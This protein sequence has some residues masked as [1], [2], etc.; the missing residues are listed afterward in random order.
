MG[1]TRSKPFDISKVLVFEAWK[2]VKANGGSYGVDK[3]SVK[4]FESN[5]KDNLYKLWNRLSSG[6]YFPPPVRRVEIPKSGGGK[7]PLGIP[8]VADRVA[9]MVVKMAL[10]PKVEPHFHKDSYGYRPGRSAI[11]AVGVARKRCWRYAWVVDLD[12]KGFF[13]NIDHELMM[14]A[15][16]AHTDCK[17]MILYIERWLKAP[18]QLAD[19]TL[20]VRNKGTPQ[21]GVAS[22]LLANLFLHYAFD[23]W[24]YRASPDT[25]FERYADDAIIHCRTLQEAEHV[26]NMVERRLAECGLE[27]HEQK[28]KIV[29]CKDSKRKSEYPQISFDFLGFCFR[30]RCMMNK[31]GQMFTG[32]GPAISN[33]SKRKIGDVIRA[34]RLQRWVAYD[35]KQIAQILNPII[36]GWFN[37]Y[38]CFYKSELYKVAGSLD[39]A[40]IRW[41][42]KKFKKKGSLRKSR[43]FLRKL[44]E[45]QPRL[46]AHWRLLA[47]RTMGAG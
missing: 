37:Y 27:L 42:K 30:P 20:L 25:P 7:R 29:L 35:E 23:L 26:R 2:K 39:F 11:D 4:L 5:L 15:V 16:K 47:D 17:W 32:F 34:W 3:Q 21:G 28:T 24:L 38:G 44:R 6:C 1:V 33:T 19:S 46:F 45:Q 18:V 22:P 8:T 36:A 31:K 13:D 40:L 12:I 41:I 14:K 43:K 9:Q 10:E